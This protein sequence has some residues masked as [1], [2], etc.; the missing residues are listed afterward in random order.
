MMALPDMDNLVENT[1]IT[2]DTVFNER[3][4]GDSFSSPMRASPETR[5]K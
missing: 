2:M 1:E 3:S 4:Y 5:G